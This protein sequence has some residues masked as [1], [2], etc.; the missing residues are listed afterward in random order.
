MGR[1][2]NFIVGFELTKVSANKPNIKNPYKLT[3]PDRSNW[4]TVRF[5]FTKAFRKLLIFR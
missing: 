2:S 3:F 5:S 1:L 4:E